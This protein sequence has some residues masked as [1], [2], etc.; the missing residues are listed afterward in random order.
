MTPTAVNSFKAGLLVLACS[1]AFSPAIAG[2]ID[3]EGM[4]EWEIC[5]MCHS[6]NGISRMAKF[7]KLAGQKSAYISKQFIDFY[8]GRRSNDGGQMEAITTEVDIASVDSIANYF[9]QLPPPAAAELGSDT[10]SLLL[11]SE[12]EKVFYKGVK[13]TPAC[14]KCHDRSLDSKQQKIVESSMELGQIAP[15]L[16][17]QHQDYLVKQLEDFKS[18]N[19]TNDA[20]ETMHQV[21]AGLTSKRM[22]A[23]AFY[24]AHK[25][26]IKD[27][28]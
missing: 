14:A 9:S 20:S 2:M 18:G 5:A 21:A 22:H 17:G 16:F 6:L 25:Q 1:I 3:K 15:W 23:V 19:R 24:L 13:N 7:P 28:K 26:P 27:A 11:F 4:A 8:N 10:E 12:G